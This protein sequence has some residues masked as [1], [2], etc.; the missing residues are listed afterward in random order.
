MCTLFS[1]GAIRREMGDLKWT[2]GAIGYQCGLA[3]MVSFVIYQL[4]HVLVEKGTLTLGTFSDGCCF[5]WI[6]F[7][8]KKTKARQRKCPSNHFFRKRVITDGNNYFIHFNFWNSR[9][10]HLSTNQ[11][12]ESCE[13]CQTACPVKRT[14]FT[15]ITTEKIPSCINNSGVLQY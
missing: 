10:H 7:P 2:L 13:D 5:S 14:I 8:Y 6:L 15:R 12:G 1:I 9:N 3:Y 4:G 11:K